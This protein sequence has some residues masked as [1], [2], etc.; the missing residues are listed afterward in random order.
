[1]NR[2]VDLETTL[3]IGGSGL[4]DAQQMATHTQQTM[5]LNKH[6]PLNYQNNATKMMINPLTCFLFYTHMVCKVC[7]TVFMV[8]RQ[9]S[10]GD[11]SCYCCSGYLFCWQVI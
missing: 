3:F 4:R 7:V 9:Y 10:E 1:M 5:P 2:L 11:Y 8:A 6:L